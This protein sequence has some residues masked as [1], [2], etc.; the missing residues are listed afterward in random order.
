M[1]DQSHRFSKGCQLCQQGR[2]LCI[3]LTFR[4]NAGC[5]FCPAPF[6]DDRINSSLGKQKE[7]ILSYLV[8][9]DL[10]GISF[11]GG[12]PFLVFDRLLEWLSFFRK[13]LPEYY[14]WVYT[15][16]LEVTEEKMR[17]LVAEGMNEIRFNIA[18][19]NYLN[20]NVWDKI[21]AARNIF[22][23]V[24]VEI[25]SIEQDFRLLVQALDKID[26]TGVDFLNLHDFI[27]NDPVAINE[28]GRYSD[29]ILNKVIPLR[30]DCSSAR[31]TEKI[32]ELTLK[33]GYG[34]VINRCSMQQKESQMQQRRFKMGALFNNPEYD[35]VLSDGTICNFYFVPPTMTLF[36]M[37]ID[38]D[39]P[40][41]RN[42]LNSYM[43]KLNDPMIK[44]DSVARIIKAFYIPRMGTDQDK[45]FLGTEV[46]RIKE[47]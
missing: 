46:W 15:S 2:W 47:I 44:N 23:F 20:K 28:D 39:N 4:C 30:Y 19:T 11:S 35:L 36:E 40:D 9:T 26:R 42:K 5:Q 7:E 3:F 22:P 45:I 31:N 29:F 33:K 6:R 13:H 14:F 41:L 8:K 32:I 34:F 17:R 12:D 18:A 16:G 1:T 25:P 38:L 21:T 27:I 24:S 43:L 37:Q 10:E